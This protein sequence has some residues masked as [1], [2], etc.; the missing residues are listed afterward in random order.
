MSD[1]IIK[2]QQFENI[3]FDLLS[4][5]FQTLIG[6]NEDCFN[7]DFKNWM[8][9]RFKIAFN[10]YDFEQIWNSLAKKNSINYFGIFESFN[11]STAFNKSTPPPKVLTQEE[12]DIQEEEK[13]RKKNEEINEG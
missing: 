12:K 7:E 13:K 6:D 3:N 11:L 1:S 8:I 10:I 2:K 4:P 9:S 5:S